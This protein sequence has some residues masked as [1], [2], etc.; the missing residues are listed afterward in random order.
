MITAIRPAREDDLPRI[1]DIYNHEVLT[2]T[3]TYDTQPRSPAEQKAWFRH[4]GG[5]HPVLVAEREGHVCGWAS[6]SPW[7][8]RP[9][10]RRTVE[11]SVY[12]AEEA[13]RRGVGRALLKAL[14]DA[15]AS[16]GHH[17]L[18]A[19]IS[20]DNAASIR[21]HEALGF[22]VAGTLAEVGVKFDR[23]LDVCVMELILPGS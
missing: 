13:R 23:V 14:I 9:A 6:L 19:R 8:D 17:A 4:H 16:L 15:A 11:V 3:A 1:R 5:S 18:L 7:S 12:V 20:A 10:Y 21:L 2:S 22:F